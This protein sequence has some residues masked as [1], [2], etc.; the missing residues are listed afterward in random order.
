M[1]LRRGGWRPSG[2]RRRV[3]PVR[4]VTTP[5]AGRGGL[6]VT[7]GSIALVLAL[8]SGARARDRRRRVRSGA[9]GGLR[10]ARR[11]RGGRAD[12][13]GLVA[14]RR[15]RILGPVRAARPRRR[16]SRSVT[17]GDR[18]ESGD[19]TGT[20]CI[21]AAGRG[22]AGAGLLERA[23]TGCPSAAGT[24]R[25]TDLGLSVALAAFGTAAAGIVGLLVALL[26]QADPH[27][28][29]PL[30][31]RGLR[32]YSAAGHYIGVTP[33]VSP[34]R[35][36]P[37]DRRQGRLRHECRGVQRPRSGRHRRH[38]LPPARLLGPHRPHPAVA[39]RRQGERV[40]AQVL[41]QGP[42]RAQDDQDAARRRPEA[43][44]GAGGLRVPARPRRR[45]Q[46]RPSS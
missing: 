43:R 8:R 42:R 46:P 9:A 1:T 41:L 4:A 24:R 19:A 18:T 36:P 40:A 35:D 25:G 16:Q 28:K 37:P 45:P 31:A 32:S 26:S 27:G 5:G 23:R 11:Q 3:N 14:A 33:P 22:H 15:L 13:P 20:P 34:R 2:P 7:D 6:R 17:P 29:Q 21:L 38:H 44:A 30:T 12:R 39:G 10:G